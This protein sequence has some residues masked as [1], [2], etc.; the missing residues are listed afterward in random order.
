MSFKTFAVP[1]ILLF[2]LCSLPLTANAQAAAPA[3]ALHDGD[4]VTFYGDSITNQREYTED[5]EEYVLTRFPAWK[6]SFHNAGV[7]GDKVSGG[8]AGPI[9]LRLDRD[10]FAWHPNVV[11][12]M[13]GMNDFYYRS[14]EPGI[15]STYTDGYRHL[16]DSLKKNVPGVHITLIEPSPYD[17]VTRK[18]SGNNDV[19]LKYSA[20]VAQLAQENGAQVAD[21]NTPVTDVL[22]AINSASPALAPQ[23]IPDRVHPEQ[24]GHWVMAESMLKIWQAPSLVTSVDINAGVKP[25]AE[26]VNTAVTGLTREK[27]KITAKVSWTQADKALPLPFPPSELDPVL[28]LVLKYSDVVA[29]L[30]QETLKVSALTAGSYDLV[31]DG[32][33]IGSFTAAQLAGGIN[34]ATMDTP[35]LEQALLVAFDTEKVNLLESQRF[36]IIRGT[37]TPEQL[38]TAQ[39]LADAYPAAVA[40][41]RADAQP[42]THHYELVLV[43][44]APTGK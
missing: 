6:V 16:V 35:M 42:L 24:G 9:D 12:V 39:A 20:F 41:Q 25:T 32:R 23:V 40:R 43:S 31:I 37:A 13:L 30:D 34:L 21:F 29:A 26:A 10:V 44:P 36:Q 8:G 28:A 5:V 27:G 7:G 38:A 22:K 3:F 19:L 15:Y 11:S 18:S 17:D 4:R 1:V 14:D 2:V 33:K